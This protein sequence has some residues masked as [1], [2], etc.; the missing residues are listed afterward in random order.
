MFSY[1]RFICSDDSYIKLVFNATD[2]MIMAMLTLYR[3][4]LSGEPMNRN[5]G[6]LAQVHNN[7]SYFQRSL[8]CYERYIALLSKSNVSMYQFSSQAIFSQVKYVYPLLALGTTSKR[9]SASRS[10]RS[11]TS[12]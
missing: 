11:S 6:Q 12:F 10:K 5:V 4:T 8:G 9:P 2:A 3:G 1:L 7:L